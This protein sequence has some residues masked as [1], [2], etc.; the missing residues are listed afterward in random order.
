MSTLALRTPFVGAVTNAVNG[1]PVGGA[2]R[3]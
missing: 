1:R 2:T 3:R